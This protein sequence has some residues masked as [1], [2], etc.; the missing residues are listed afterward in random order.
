MSVNILSTTVTLTA[1]QIHALGGTPIQLLPAPGLGNYYQLLQGVF[2]Y[3]YGSSAFSGASATPYIYPTGLAAATYDF[4]FNLEVTGF[5]DQ[6]SNQILQSAGNADVSIPSSGFLN[7]G[8]S[9]A[10]P[11]QAIT[12][13]TGSTL[14][15]TLFYQILSGQ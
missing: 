10:N 3:V 4:G 5:L 6:T 2:N 7:A 9:I 15:V 12:N 11:G 14:V 1:T 8:I 13:G